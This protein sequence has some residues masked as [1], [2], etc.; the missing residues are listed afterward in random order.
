MEDKIKQ[1][2]TANASLYNGQPTDTG[3]SCPS[4][5]LTSCTPSTSKNRGG[6]SVENVPSRNKQWFVLRVTYGRIIKAKAFIEAKGIECYVPLRY[7]EVRKQGKKRIIT[8]PLISSFVFVH[9]SAE[10]V[11]SL[12]QDKNIKAFENRALLSYYYDHTSHCENAPIKN[13]PLIIA[14]TAMDNFI[15]LTSIH[16]PYI[17]PVTSENIKYKLG[18]EV[19]ITEGEFKDIRGRVTRIAGQ[20]RVV[21]ELFDGCLVATAYIPKEAMKKIEKEN[22][23]VT[24]NDVENAYVDSAY[25]SERNREF[26][27][28]KINIISGGLQ[29]KPSRFDL[30]LKADQTLEV[31]GKITGEIKTAIPVNRMNG[32]LSLRTPMAR[33][34]IGISRRSMW[35]RLR[36]DAKL[37]PYRLKNGKNST[38]QK[39]SCS[40]MASIQETTRPDTAHFL[41]TACRQ[42]Q[43]TI[44]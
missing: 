32:R 36:S 40:S 15:R 38:T 18:D 10:Q 12:L 14:D 37:S 41:S 9:A 5:R 43:D 29:G 4:A 8:E 3:S 28:D 16:N 42:L 20:Q 24:G 7:K 31:T 22:K 11:D 13:P 27:K 17:I 21:V 35:T 34:H 44:G 33:S 39:Q 30:N 23:K 25:Q 26:A 6:V 1:P 19:V 2:L